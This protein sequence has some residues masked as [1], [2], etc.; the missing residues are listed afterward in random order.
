MND[1]TAVDAMVVIGGKYDESRGNNHVLIV[2]SSGA[3]SDSKE[4]FISKGY[5][6]LVDGEVI[7]ICKKKEDE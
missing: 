6:Y 1:L 4:P 3:R 2:A 7:I 5:N